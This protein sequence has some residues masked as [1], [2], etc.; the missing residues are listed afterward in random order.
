MKVW[1]AGIA[2]TVVGGVLVWWLTSLGGPFDRK[3]ADPQLVALTTAGAALVG[4]PPAAS[5]TVR[6]DGDGTAS[7]CRLLSSPFSNDVTDSP[8][9]A[10]GDFS[11]AAGQEKTLPL[12]TTATYAT[13]GPTDMAAELDCEDKEPSRLT[14]TVLVR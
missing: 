6:N 8:F 3:E 2:A 13:P 4:Q 11:L 7:S 1:F 14:K 10:S 9:P 12:R 5:A